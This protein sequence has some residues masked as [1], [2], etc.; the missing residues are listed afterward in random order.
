MKNSSGDGIRILIIDDE[1]GHAEAV[2][3]TLERIGY[4]CEIATSGDEGAKRIEEEEFHLILTDLRMNDQNGMDILRK[5]KQELPDAVVVMITGH[6]NVKS[7][8]EAMQA[9]AASYLTKPVGRDELR[10]VI[11]KAAKQFQ[12]TKQNR[13]LKQQLDE[14]FGFEGVIGES[15]QMNQVIDKLKNVSPTGASVL[16]LGETGTGK[17]L[18]ARAIHYNSPRK[19]KPFIALNCTALNPNLLDDELFG[20]EAHSYTGADKMRKGRFEAAHEGTLFLDEIGDMPL[21]LQAKLLRVLETHE[22]TRIGSNEPVKVNVRVIAAT[23]KDLKQAVADGEFRQDLYQR[24][25]VVVVSLPPLRE[26]REDIPRLSTRFVEHFCKENGKP[27]AT[28]SEAVMRA[29]MAYHWE[30]NVRELR[31]LIQSMVIHDSDNVLDM[32]DL[33]MADVDGNLSSTDGPEVSG[34]D[35]LIGR[36]LSEVERYYIE[37]TLKL[38]DGNRSEAAQM[39]GIGER[40]LYRQLNDWKLDDDIRAAWQEHDGN[41]DQLSEQFEMKPEE[42]LRKLKKLGL[43]TEGN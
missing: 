13:E 26:R 30:G 3:E 23:H 25:R 41:V 33:R 32:E 5:A 15:R 16:I 35:A 8:V 36:P 31:N 28:I 4:Q 20:H 37:Q 17:E 29:M 6:S 21:E 43:S 40:T 2:S 22:I 11:D 18:V 42:L 1:E 7:A 34:A 9:G 19:N 27:I 24:L 38:T 39:L 10:A 12:L 14:K